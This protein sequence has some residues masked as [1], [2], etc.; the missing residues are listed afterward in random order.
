MASDLIYREDAKDFVR[1]AY[2]KG[3]NPIDY[4][5]EVPAADVRPVNNRYID[6]D[7][8]F[9]RIAGHSYYSGDDILTRISLMQE[10]KSPKKKD[11]K[12]ADVRPVVRA[13]WIVIDHGDYQLIECGRCHAQ[14]WNHEKELPNYCYSCGA[15]MRKLVE[16]E[17][18]KEEP[19][20]A[21]SLDWLYGEGKQG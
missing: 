11:V 2:H 9:K 4:L 6:G 17:Q 21:C 19:C 13:E 12:P 10:G 18:V 15:D 14:M 8:L 1:H 20:E 7:E 16:I 3:L 5:D